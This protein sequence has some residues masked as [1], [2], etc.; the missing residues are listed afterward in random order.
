[1]RPL[2][3]LNATASDRALNSTLAID[4][5]R[6]LGILYQ[7]P[8]KPMTDTIHLFLL[9]SVLAWTREIRG[10]SRLKL[11]Q[12]SVQRFLPAPFGL[13]LAQMAVGL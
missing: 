5:T 4:L 11:F 7:P 12:I 9:V 1:M 13:P 2:S 10:Q 8:S 3:R 6:T